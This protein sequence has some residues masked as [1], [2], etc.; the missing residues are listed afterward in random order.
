MTYLLDLIQ[1]LTVIAYGIILKL[2]IIINKK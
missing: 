2:K 1:I